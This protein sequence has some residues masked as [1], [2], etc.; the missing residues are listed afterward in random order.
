MNGASDTTAQKTRF[1]NA[2][3]LIKV[4]HGLGGIEWWWTDQIRTSLM[5]SF[6]QI[7]APKN[8]PILSG[9]TQI[10]TKI[11]KVIANIVY[12]P[13]ANIDI[14][15]EILSHVRT[16]L[17]GTDTTNGTSYTTYGGGTGK[18]TRVITSFVYRF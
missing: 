1:T 11:K 3:D 16:T 18:A 7:A 13:V 14:G 5:G 6:T 12:S 17:S 2:F 8:M 9:S 4:K 15:L 10:N